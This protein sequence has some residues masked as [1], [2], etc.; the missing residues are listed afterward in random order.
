[1]EAM[2]VLHHRSSFSEKKYNLLPPPNTSMEEFKRL[3]GSLAGQAATKLMNDFR[4]RHTLIG[5]ND[6]VDK[7]VSMLVKNYGYR[8]LPTPQVYEFVSPEID[9]D[10]S[11]N[12]ILGEVREEL[13]RHNDVPSWD[14]HHQAVS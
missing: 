8:L 12:Q 11:V 3:C 10:S 6:I 9:S 2:F 4:Y 13:L 5:W 7:V 14:C 1:M